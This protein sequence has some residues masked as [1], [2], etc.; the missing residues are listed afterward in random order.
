MQGTELSTEVAKVL[1]MAKTRQKT[2][3]M[4]LKA[5]N[6][7]KIPKINQAAKTSTPPPKT[8]KRG[9]NN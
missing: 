5:R 6:F 2:R 1:K 9:A 8:Q 7:Q 3:K 4:V